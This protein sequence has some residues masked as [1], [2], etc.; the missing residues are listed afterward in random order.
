MWKKYILYILFC[1]SL[2]FPV[3]KITYSFET[4][5]DNPQEGK[6]V[7]FVLKQDKGRDSL[8]MDH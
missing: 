2:F 6:T 5:G 3:T 1:S 8:Y 7:L 4:C